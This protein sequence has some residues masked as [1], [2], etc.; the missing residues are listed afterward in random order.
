MDPI[1]YQKVMLR[2]IKMTTW[3]GDDE[4]S[5][6]GS[7]YRSYWESFTVDIGY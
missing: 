1:S 7:L 6:K 4:N 3:L 5:G 2:G